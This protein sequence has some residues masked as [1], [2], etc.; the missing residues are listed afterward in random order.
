MLRLNEH[1]QHIVNVYVQKDQRPNP[2]GP[3][4]SQPHTLI[5]RRLEDDHP[6]VV[7]SVEDLEELGEAGDGEERGVAEGRGYGAHLLP[8]FFD[9]DS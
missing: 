6:A 8:E 3:S 2:A 4:R 5:L 9:S 7:E 1:V